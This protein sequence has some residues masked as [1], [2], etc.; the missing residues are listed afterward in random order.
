MKKSTLFASLFIVIALLSACSQAPEAVITETAVLTV[1]SEELTLSELEAYETLSA[2]YTNKDGETTTY[3]GAPLVD[4]LQDA[5]LTEG[6]T[7]I[8]T[9]SD[10]YEAEMP[11]D[12]ALNCANCI[13]A[14]DDDIL[15]MIMP[16]MSS[17]LQVK[18]V[19]KISVK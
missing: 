16:D 11:L 12:E 19:V 18:D 8:F 7:L 2:D 4:L 3:E 5:K 10:G 17:K 13:V 6:D 15:R 14:V 9:A 1:G